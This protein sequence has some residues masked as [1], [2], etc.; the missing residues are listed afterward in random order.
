MS[1]TNS[2]PGLIKKVKLVII[3]TTLSNKP[4]K[5]RKR[6]GENIVINKKKR[7]YLLNQP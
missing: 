4:L 5:R 7:L 6:I 2:K 1:L 3:K